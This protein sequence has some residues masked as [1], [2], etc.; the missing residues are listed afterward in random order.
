VREKFDYRE[1]LR[2][3]SEDEKVSKTRPVLLTQREIKEMLL[4][5]KQKNERRRKP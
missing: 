3:I 5:R 2:E 4:V 1:M